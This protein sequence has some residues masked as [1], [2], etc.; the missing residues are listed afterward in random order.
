MSLRVVKSDNNIKK[1]IPLDNNNKKVLKRVTSAEDIKEMEETMFSQWLIVCC[2]H[3][4]L[5]QKE[6]KNE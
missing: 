4:K 2:R 1:R 6:G 5:K 3:M